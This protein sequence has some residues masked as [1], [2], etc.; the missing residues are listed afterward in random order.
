[1]EETNLLVSLNASLFRAATS[2]PSTEMLLVGAKFVKGS[3]YKLFCDK[4]GN[5]KIPMS[6]PRN[7]SKP[8][9]AALS[10]CGDIISN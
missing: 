4:D 6:E 2:S 3:S 10:C 5:G 9:N 1:V 7:S 8:K